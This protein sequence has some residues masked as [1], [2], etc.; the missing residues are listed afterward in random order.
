MELKVC[1]LTPTAVLIALALGG[2]TA[3]AG[4]QASFM[5]LGYLPG[6]HDVSMASGVSGDGWAAVGSSGSSPPGYASGIEPFRW[7]RSGGMVGLRSLAPGGNIDGS[8]NGISADGSVVV[9][10]SRVFPGVDQAYRWTS[11]NGMISLGVLPGGLPGSNAF[12][13]SSD[14]SVI[15]GQATAADGA[16][17]PMRWTEDRGMMSLGRLFPNGGGRASAVSADGS[18]V[19][20][21]SGL[22]AFRWTESDGMV[23]LGD[24]PRGAA[25]S[26]G[27][28][29][30]ADGS[31]VVGWGTTLSGRKAARW[32]SSSGW[33]ALPDLA[34]NLGYN[35]MAHAVSADGSV[36]VGESYAHS[37]VATIWDSQGVRSIQDVLQDDL[38]LD[39]SGWT[40][41]RATGISDDG[42]TIVGT[43]RNPTGVSEAWI[44]VIPEPATA[45]MLA[46]G[47]LLAF[48]WAGLQSNSRNTF[49][50]TLRS[51]NIPRTHAES[52]G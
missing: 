49:S 10:W 5:G 13:A 19:V 32:A 9:G 39:L 48:R 17:E 25:E 15:V 51:R 30:S 1:V 21:S 16:S 33:S 6:G 7:T 2:A 27:L 45:F 29:V 24:L 44:A 40:L 18:V 34:G 42:S 28:D 8:A 37:Y 3:S 11:D 35:S 41:W 50:R 12:G 52:G 26:D 36:I 14:G 47:S 46:M 20:G 38:D 22:F 23:S 43:G 4:A 31:V